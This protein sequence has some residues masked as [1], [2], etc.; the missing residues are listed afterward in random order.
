MITREQALQLKHGDILYHIAHVNADGSPA[1]WRVTGKV[2]TWKTRPDH[3]KIPVKNGLRHY[4]Y[5][6]HDEAHLVCLDEAE[7]YRIG[8]E[9]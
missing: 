1:R 9:I 8:R 3:F 5:V 6:T 4:S 2:Q 7:A